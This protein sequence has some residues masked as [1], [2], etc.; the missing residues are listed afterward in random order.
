MNRTYWLRRTLE[1]VPASNSWLSPAEQQR[2]GALQI[3]KRR[4]DWRL[5]RWT[6]KQAISLCLN[7]DSQQ[8]NALALVEIRAAVSGAPEAF[9]RDQRANV[10]VSLSHRDGVCICAIAPVGIELGCDLEC[11]EPHSAEFIIDYFDEKE[12]NVIANA[13]ADDQILLV[14]LMWSAKESALKAIKEG[15][16][17]DARSARVS[18]EPRNVQARE[19]SA[20]QVTA[21]D[22]R[23]HGWWKTDGKFVYTF[24]A[25]PQIS[26]PIYLF[27]EEDQSATAANW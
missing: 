19:W 24:A 25:Y 17:V 18:L 14:S 3:P 11:I 13:P 23:F 12:L 20:L 16:R 22:R 6:A 7:F 2:L 4:A 15:L 8:H 26:Q 9:I 21:Q 5:G 27:A 1:D 10:S